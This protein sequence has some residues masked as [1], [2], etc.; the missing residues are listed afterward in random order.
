MMIHPGVIDMAVFYSLACH[1]FDAEFFGK[2]SHA[3]S[4]PEAGI[5]ALEALIL[6]YNAVNSLRQHIRSNERIHGIITDGGEA[7]NIVPAHSAANFIVRAE[8]DNHLEKLKERFLNCFTGA[9]AATGA[10]LEYEWDENYYAAMNNNMTAAKL[11]ADNMSNLG[12]TVIVPDPGRPSGSTDM[13]NVSQVVPSI[14]P[15]VSIAP[16]GTSLHSVE[17][18]EAA[19]SEAG[20]K[21]M[22]DASKALAM[23]VIDLLANPETMGK[24]KK[25]F[26]EHND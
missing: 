25:E 24:I 22:L 20:I 12:R 15:F 19:N 11:Y 7:A 9:A 5:N 16:K 23:T 10:R 2:A 8:N 6:A 1:N 3:A 17:F 26:S 18:A 14:H 13:G 4:A 21:G